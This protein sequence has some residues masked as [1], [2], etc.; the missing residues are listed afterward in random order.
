MLE[1]RVRLHWAVRTFLWVI[2]VPTSAVE[3]KREQYR[4]PPEAGSVIVKDSGETWEAV[5]PDLR[6]QDARWDMQA[7][8]QM[9]DAGSGYPPHWR[10]EAGDANL[11][12]ASAMQGP[13]ERH[14]LRRQQYF[15]FMLE[16]ILFHAYQRACELGQRP[17]LQRPALRSE[18][19][20]EWFTAVLPEISRWDN[21][22]LARAAKELGTALQAARSILGGDSHQFKRLA[23]ELICRFAGVPQT[24]QNLDAILAEAG[25]ATSLPPEEPGER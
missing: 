13:T 16:D 17:P 24:D 12:T 20:A 22:S 9:I 15:V 8:R 25:A 6:A 10:G 21:E 4:N 1:D 3:A 7:V 11:A 23:M 14:L 5:A 19:Y 18:D 2:S